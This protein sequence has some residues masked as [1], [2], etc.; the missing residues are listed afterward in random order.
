MRPIAATV[1]VIQGAALLS[2]GVAV[3]WVVIRD[4]IT[5]PAAVASP[6]GIA[7]EVALF[8]VFGAAMLWIARGLV[9]GSGA[10]LTPFVLAQVLGLTVSIPLATGTGAAAVVGWLLTGLCILGLVAWV[11]LLRSRSAE[12]A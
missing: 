2:N 3:L 7:V 1:A 4:G 8:V 11:S 5:G 12:D 10:V 9:R 6:A